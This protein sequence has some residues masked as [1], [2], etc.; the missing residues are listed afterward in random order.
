MRNIEFIVNG[1]IID[2]VIGLHIHRSMDEIAG[3]FA[4]ELDDAYSTKLRMDYDIQI[5]LNGSSVIT[6]YI[7]EIHENNTWDSES[8]I[9]YGSDK[10]GD[11]IDCPYESVNREFKNQ[12]VASIIKKICLSFGISTTFTSTASHLQSTILPTYVANMGVPAAQLISELLRDFGVVAPPMGDGKLTVTGAGV[13]KATDT[14]EYGKNIVFSKAIHSNRNRYKDNYV[15][16]YGISTD[17]KGM[18]DY[19]EPEGKA[20]DSVITRHRPNV[21]FFE[22]IADKSK[23]N[24]RA[25][26]E[27]QIRA[28]LSRTPIYYVDNWDQSDASIWDINLLTTPN[29]EKQGF[30]KEM[31]INTIDY[32]LNDEMSDNKEIQPYSTLKLVYPETYATSGTIK[33]IYDA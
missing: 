33:G 25:Q 23:C 32:Y 7:D 3:T 9:V 29:D 10:T 21:Q 31:I 19:T 20:S 4:I 11:L 15:R 2:E 5:K 22:N 30:T 1:N 18:T 14:L 28:G 26:Y 6:G 12:S 24:R 27:R 16:G 17:N 8:I 13:N